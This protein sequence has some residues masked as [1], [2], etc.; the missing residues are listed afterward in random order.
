MNIYWLNPP[1]SSR[2]IT[3]DLAWVNFS[4]LFADHNWIQPILDWDQF[5]DLDSVL[6]HVNQQPIDILMISCYTWNYALCDSVA[7]SIKQQHPHCT[8]VAG[9]PHLTD[10]KP[11]VD[12]QCYAMGHGEQFLQPLLAQLQ[13]HGKVVDPDQIPFLIMSNYKSLI[14]SQKY[15]FPD[16]SAYAHNQHYISQAVSAAR[17][18]NRAVG[19]LIETARGCPYACTYCEWGGGIGTKI[20]QRSLQSVYEDIETLAMLGIDEIDIVDANFG[21]LPRDVDIAKKLVEAKKLWGSPKKVGL[22]GVA[23]T[24]AAKREAVLDEL[25]ASGLMDFYFMAIQ[26]TNPDTLTNV[27]RTDISVE[28]NLQLA[29]KYKT[30]YNSSA[31]VELIMGLPGSTLDEFYEEMNLFYQMEN[32]FCPRNMFSLLPNTEA[33]SESYRRQFKLQTAMVGSFENDEQDVVHINKNVLS[34]FR[35]AQEVV[36]ASYSFS[37]EDWKQ[38]FF[39][40]RAQRVIGPRVK[41][42]ASVELRQWFEQIRT[43]AWYQLI[44]QWMSR[45]VAGELSDTDI[46]LINGQTI[47]DIVAYHCP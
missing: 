44:D 43:T 16:S 17:A 37:I 30:L 13:L 35:S 15:R 11:W 29:K 2:S 3:C 5:V 32:W 28:E 9:G 25:L 14:T 41:H 21:I 12:Y 20:S 47:E 36:I 23:K 40:N 24:K 46:N 45:I 31:K 42:N 34:H 39:M 26:T 22:Y 19:A 6:S 38:M 10:I 7:S 33:A 18:S 27:K 1:L 8:V 4:F